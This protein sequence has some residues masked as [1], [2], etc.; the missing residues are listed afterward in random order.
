MEGVG[1]NPNGSLSSILSALRAMEENL[2]CLI[3]KKLLQEPTLMTCDHIFC[4]ECIP[5]YMV[6]LCPICKARFLSKNLRPAPYIEDMLKRYREVEASIKN[7]NSNSVSPVGAFV[8]ES[9]LIPTA[10]SIESTSASQ[11]N[12]SCQ[13]DSTESSEAIAP[14]PPGLNKKEKPNASVVKDSCSVSCMN[15]SSNTRRNKRTERK[16]LAGSSVKR[17]KLMSSRV[18]HGLYEDKCIFCHS[19]R[20]NIEGFGE[21]LCIQ[22]GKVV[23]E[24][25]KSSKARVLHAHEFCLHWAPWVYYQGDQIMNLE[26][27]IRRTSKLTCAKCNLKGAALGCFYEPCPKS[28]HPSCAYQVLGCRWDTENYNMLCP[29]HVSKKLPCDS[30]S[31]HSDRAATADVR[32]PA[33][34]EQPNQ[35]GK[36][37]QHQ[38]NKGYSLTKT[39]ARKLS[40]QKLVLLGLHLSLPEKEMLARFSDKF[41]AILSTEWSNDATHVVISCAVQTCIQLSHAYEVMMAILHGTWIITIEWIKE[42]LEE[43]GMLEEESYEVKE[44]FNGPIEGP[45]KGRLRVAGKAPNLFARIGFSLSKDFPRSTECRLKELLVS[46]GGKILEEGST[47]DSGSNRRLL[48]T[49]LVYS[50]KLLQESGSSRMNQLL[51]LANRMRCAQ[52]VSH[53][54]VEEAIVNFDTDVFNKE[55]FD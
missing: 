3:C 7:A 11:I 22:D 12:N 30:G 16:E 47:M 38:Q 10:Q 14:V 55:W 52:I 31:C 2:K 44:D 32:R 49:Y 50:G 42:S 23:V 19:S 48:T 27:E 46:G 29:E 45:R 15:P 20:Q 25:D 51:D 13:Q 40:T 8:E 17:K 34:R 21:L 53:K 24:P 43:G 1:M 39:E 35:L 26:S 41:G 37:V 28:Y 18:L 6:S 54:R 9:T 4:R 33:W 36:I 5:K